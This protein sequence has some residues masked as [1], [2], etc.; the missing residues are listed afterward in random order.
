[1]KTIKF[2]VCG[3]GRRGASVTRNVLA[4]LP[5]VTL[6]ALADP[7]QD[8]AE[9]L[10]DELLEKTGHRPNVYTDYETLFEKE[11]PDA[12]FVA[13]SWDTHVPIAVHAMKK[14]VA[15]ALEVGALYSEQECWD[16]IEAYEQTKTPFML[17]ENACYNKD[18]LLADAMTKD[19]CFGE[20]VYC[21]GAY[22]HD[23]RNQ[24]AYG[25]LKRHFRQS[26][27]LT[28]NRDSYP[29]HDLGPIARILNINCGNRMVSLCSRASKA[30]GLNAYAKERE[31]VSY[32]AD[33][34]FAQGDIVETLITCENGELISLRLDTTLPTFYNRELMV[35]G[36]KGLYDQKCNLVLLDTDDM[37]KDGRI[38]FIMKETNNA[39]KYYDQYLP[40]VWKNITQEALEA[41]H[42]GID[43]IEFEVFCDRLRS[44][45]EMPMDVY[46]AAAW[47]SISYLSEQSIAANGAPVEIP[48]FTKGAYKT[49]KQVSLL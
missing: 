13:S 46:D 48:D 44:G 28:R 11:T 36:T 24:L 41:G 2:A 12:V 5:D 1:M 49:R 25:E 31:E 4:A 32:L 42:G 43:M 9:D 15:V 18:E 14:G 38:N 8:K 10:A 6:C 7:Y 30:R 45:R 39:T 29:T 33:T 16:L 17:M 37:N 35:R 3:C 27:Y 47:M 40:D 19:D 21:H 22:M 20:I 26:E 34:H 23:L